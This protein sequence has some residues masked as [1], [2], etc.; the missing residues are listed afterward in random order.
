MRSF[1][2][3][4]DEG[5]LQA[6][7]RRLHSSQPTVG[8]HI[9]LL[10]QQLGARL[11]DR[12]A[13]QLLPTNLALEIA[14]HARNMESCAQAIGLTLRAKDE[15]AIDQVRLSASQCTSCY[16]LPPILA[17]LQQ[18]DPNVSVELVSSNQA[19][20]LQKREADIAIRMVRPSEESVVARRIGRVPLGAYAHKRYLQQHGV[21][22]TPS[23]LLQHRLI[24]YDTQQAILMGFAQW[25]IQAER[26][27]FQFRTD[28]HLLVWQLLNQGL[29]VGF[30]AH[31]IALQNPDMVRIL[32]DFPI[33]PLDVWITLHED[34]RASPGIRRI[35]DFLAEHLSARLQLADNAELS[36]V[37]PAAEAMELV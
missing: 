37:A 2:A 30:T 34:L 1:I 26:Q 7:A 19:V 27:H 35:F 8:R 10:E 6:A 16:L 28:D 12:R 24:G 13:R 21:P 36:R 29:G 32:E 31:Y 18:E 20:N 23:D 22:Q 33:A 9:A 17:Q 25:G 5:S 4:I 15:K 11:F 14:N 3:V